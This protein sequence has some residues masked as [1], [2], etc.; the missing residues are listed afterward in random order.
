M[1]LNFAFGLLQFGLDKSLERCSDYEVQEMDRS[2]DYL[3]RTV[4]R[5]GYRRKRDESILALQA[6]VPSEKQRVA[7]LDDILSEYIM[8]D[9]SM[10]NWTELRLAKRGEQ[11]VRVRF[12]SDF[13]SDEE[14]IEMDEMAD[15]DFISRAG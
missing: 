5:E 13:D 11:Q 8:A 10:E 4:T 1:L 15:A 9:D 3:T 12:G 14:W 2:L 6:A 7:L